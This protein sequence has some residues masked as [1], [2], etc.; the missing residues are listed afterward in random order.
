MKAHSPAYADVRVDAA[1]AWVIPCC[2]LSIDLLA[3]V[4]LNAIGFLW[5]V[6]L[7]LVL[8]VYALVRVQWVGEIRL[9]PG[10]QPQVLIQ[11]VW[12]EAVLLPRG[13]VSPWMILLRLHLDSGHRVYF[14]SRP[15]SGNSKHV[16]RLRVMLCWI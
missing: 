2:L 14:L 4:A 3:A 11:G 6:A 12:W 10:E 15:F 1:Q 7:P 9:V 16:R 5:L 8:S 13:F